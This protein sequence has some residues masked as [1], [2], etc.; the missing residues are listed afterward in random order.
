[1]VI[2]TD[3]HYEGFISLQLVWINIWLMRPIGSCRYHK[4]NCLVHS[5]VQDKKQFKLTQGWPSNFYKHLYE[6]QR[7]L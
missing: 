2:Y 1:M 5:S 7:A 6:T 3:V 4:D